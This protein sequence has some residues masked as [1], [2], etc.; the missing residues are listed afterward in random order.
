MSTGKIT[1]Y[2]TWDEEAKVWW[3]R[4]DDIGGLSTEAP[5]VEDLISKLN[6]IIPDLVRLNGLPNDEAPGLLPVCVISDRLMQ[7]DMQAAP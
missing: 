6:A 7:V 3:A 2:A 4:S 5:T 1:V